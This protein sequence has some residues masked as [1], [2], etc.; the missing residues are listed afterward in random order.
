MFPDTQVADSQATT[1]W[2]GIPANHTPLATTSSAHQS[3]VAPDVP[4]LKAQATHLPRTLTVQPSRTTTSRSP[5]HQVP[6]PAATQ[7]PVLHTPLPPQSPTNQ[8]APSS[9]THTY[10][11]TPQVPRGG[12]SDPQLTPM[13]SATPT[14][15]PT[16]L[17]EASP[18]GR[19]RRDDRWLL[20]ALLV[21]TCV[22]LVVLLALGIVYCTRCGPHVPNK[23][24]TDCYRW[25]THSGNKGPTEPMPHRGSLTGVQTCRTSV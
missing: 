14:A 23:R 3:P 17:G 25:V 15:G 24:I 16:A 4:V 20:V 10:S 6:V 9:P 2:S 19:S 5:A 8:N 7:P 13:P 1:H 22:F 12:A 21:P 18:A 11:K